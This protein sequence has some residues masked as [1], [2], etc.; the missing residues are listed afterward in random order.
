MN[1]ISMLFL[2]VID[3]HLHLFLSHPNSHNKHG[4]TLQIALKFSKKCAA[5]LHPWS[6]PIKGGYT[7][8]TLNGVPYFGRVIRLFCINSE[9]RLTF[10]VA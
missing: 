7:T 9:K 5:T 6:K 8:K 2:A 10:F 3:A 1:G 4:A